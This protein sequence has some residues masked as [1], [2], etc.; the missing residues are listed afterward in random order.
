MVI[1]IWS[2]PRGTK[3]YSDPQSWYP[4]TTSN[5][6]RTLI[7]NG[8]E[9]YG[10][11]TV[12]VTDYNHDGDPDLLVDG[13]LG[14]SL[15]LGKPG[16][17]FT[18]ATNILRQNVSPSISPVTADFNGDGLQDIA[19]AC[20]GTSCVSFSIGHAGGGFDETFLSPRR[21]AS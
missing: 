16:V 10:A 13:S 7:K 17:S 3:S 6:D 19:A 18:W 15:Y 8:Q 21:R 12:L 11:W 2:L 1:L 20:V 5:L 9:N 14:Y 4:L